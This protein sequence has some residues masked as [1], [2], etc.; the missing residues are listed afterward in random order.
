M[1][2]PGASHATASSSGFG[3]TEFL[4]DQQRSFMEELCALP[5]SFSNGTFSEVES[6]N[7]RFF[8]H[9]L[10]YSKRSTVPFPDKFSSWETLGDHITASHPLVKHKNARSFW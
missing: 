8:I 5:D 4:W 6:P 3:F 2:L 1:G 10:S 9:I 7:H